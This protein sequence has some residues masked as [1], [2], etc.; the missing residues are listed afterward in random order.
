MELSHNRSIIGI[1]INSALN[2]FFNK[3]SPKAHLPDSAAAQYQLMPSPSKRHSKI[4]YRKVDSVITKM[5]KLG[6]SVDTFAQELQ[7]HVRLGP[8]FSKTVKGKLSLGTRILQMGGVEKVFRHKFN[9]KDDEKLLK[10]S[11]CYLSTTAGP[12]AGLLFISNNRIAFCSE[13]S[14]KVTS[15]TGKLLKVH[16]KV[17]IP[18]R[19]IE[20]V[21]ASENAKKPTQKYVKLVTDDKFEFWFMGFLNHQRTFKYIKQTIHQPS[22]C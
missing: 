1:P 6:E 12:I 13:R 14:I 8:N 18:H 5:I 4:R 19:K 16:Y 3:S 11:Q 20:K 17:M 9:I 22:E 2:E 15:P 10:A 7:E 21:V